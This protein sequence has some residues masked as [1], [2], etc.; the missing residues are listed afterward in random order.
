MSKAKVKQVESKVLSVEQLLGADDRPEVVIHVPE[1]GGSVRL[2]ALSAGQWRD[3]REAAK[4][5][6]GTLDNENFE[7]RFLMASMVEPVLSE[8]Q[9]GQLMER[10]ALV[11]SRLSGEALKVTALEGVEEQAARFPEGAGPALG[12]PGGDPAGDDG[13]EA[14]P[15]DERG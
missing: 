9:F 1:W 3:V 11:L 5:P 14:A 7:A 13:G 15:G 4:K 10:N 12:V 8:D 6:D 2:K